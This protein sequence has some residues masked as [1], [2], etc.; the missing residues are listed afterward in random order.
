MTMVKQDDG[1]IMGDGPA[2]GM[3]QK[4][5]PCQHGLGWIWIGPVASEPGPGLRHLTHGHPSFLPKGV[6]Q[7]GR[8]FAD[9]V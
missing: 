1:P 9:I 7:A 8:M 6:L 2:D 3:N 4:R 5:C